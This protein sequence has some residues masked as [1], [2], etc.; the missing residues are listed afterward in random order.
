MS[1]CSVRGCSKEV[2]AK[3][4]CGM[5]WMRLH[6]TG[7]LEN[8][9]P[10]DWG[11]REKHP[12]YS[13]WREIFRKKSKSCSEEWMDFWKFV[14]DVGVR[15][16]TDHRLGRLDDTKEFSSLNFIWRV[17]ITKQN[18]SES[19]KEYKAR[20]QREYRKLHPERMKKYEMKR[21]FGLES[22]TYERMF[23]SQKGLCAICGNPEFDKD[24]KTGKLRDLS[25]DHCHTKG[26]I[27]KLLCRGCNQGLG[28]FKE[29]VQYLLNAIEYLNDNI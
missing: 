16:S 23:E 24:K 14:N 15:P 29:N 20:Y 19:V 26:H 28:N 9:R 25:V 7:A 17:Q 21:C 5:H 2:H 1:T 22:G 12:L 8:T 10:A 6:R 4:L 3:G 27:R 18:D 11:S 13:A